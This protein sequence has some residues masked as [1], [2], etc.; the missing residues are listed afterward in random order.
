[1]EATVNTLKI[2]L[3][4]YRD[5]NTASNKK[6]RQ[7]LTPFFVELPGLEP[8]RTESESAILPLDDTPTFKKNNILFLLKNEKY[9]F[10]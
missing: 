7:N 5:Y 8:R 1:M 9:F 4:P 2:K 3:N 6:G 10:L